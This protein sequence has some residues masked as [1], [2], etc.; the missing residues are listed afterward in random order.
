MSGKNRV[1]VKKGPAARTK[2]S[3]RKLPADLLD[4]VKSSLLPTFNGKRGHKD[5]RGKE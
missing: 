2:K 1:T 4:V 3:R 5:R